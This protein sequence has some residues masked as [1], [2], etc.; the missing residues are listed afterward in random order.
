M[1]EDSPFAFI[2]RP[3]GFCG[4]SFLTSI[5]AKGKAGNKIGDQN[6]AC[7]TSFGKERNHPPAP[8][9]QIQTSRFS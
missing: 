5:C 3:R 4:F 1:K 6:T 8:P 7:G 9:G 2:S